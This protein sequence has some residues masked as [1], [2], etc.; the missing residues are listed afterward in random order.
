MKVSHYISL[1]TL[2]LMVLI[3]R[4]CI[5]LFLPS[6]PGA[7][8]ELNVSFTSIQ[9]TMT[10]FMLGYALSMLSIGPLADC[11][12]HVK[13]ACI[14]II[15]FILASAL[16]FFSYNI[17]LLDVARF[18]QAFGG[19]CGTVIARAM[20]RKQFS[21][22]K[23]I[24]LL[25]M[26]SL[27]MAISPIIAPVAG[28]VVASYFTWRGVFFILSIVGILLLLLLLKLKKLTTD[29]RQPLPPLIK[30][31]KHLLK[32]RHFIGYSLTIGFAWFN[33][34]LFTIESPLLIQ[35]V[36]HFNEI[37]F[38][39][40]FALSI[41]G[42]VIGTRVTRY[43]ANNL[44]WDKLML[45][46]CFISILGSL[47]MLLALSGKV[48]FWYD[49]IIPMIIVMFSIGIIIPCAQGS[50]MQPFGDIAG[51]ALGLFFFIQM[52]FGVLAGLVAPFIY[53]TGAASL[54]KVMLLI[55][56]VMLF[57][58]YLLIYKKVVNKTTE[59]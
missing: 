31:Y 23:Q 6:L 52:L 25:A 32:H 39:V 7:A 5:D 4:L 24:H 2:I 12:G 17:I 30:T 10:T 41:S 34:F 27:A 8:Q 3:P 18:F 28:G 16:C 47:V 43:F 36:L 29:I 57:T 14:G 48:F 26:L 20:V 15:L 51:T 53:G 42:Y 33:Y 22:D 50:V 40:F 21:K 54:A 38:G 19:C 55:S 1:T 56:S 59:C 46:A 11:Y 45:Y 13:V 9:M 35:K 37:Y 44:G 58:F 49:I